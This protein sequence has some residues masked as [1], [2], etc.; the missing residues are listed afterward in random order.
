MALAQFP[1]HRL[2]SAL[3]RYP[4]RHRPSDR[5][6]RNRKSAPPRPLPR[7]G[8]S[9][10]RTRPPSIAQ[11][12]PQTRMADD[13]PQALP[14]GARPRSRPRS[15]S[16]QPSRAHR[17]SRSAPHEPAGPAGSAPR[18]SHTAW[19]SLAPC[20]GLRR[21]TDIPS[22]ITSRIG[23]SPSANLKPTPMACGTT[24]SI[25]KED[26]RI[27]VIPVNRLQR[28][29][30]G[31]LGRIAQVEKRTGFLPQLPILRKIASG[32]THEPDRT[33]FRDPF[34]ENVE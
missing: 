23:P 8:R 24:R 3:P 15:Y 31:K 16:L 33:P 28:H 30:A 11:A 26:G 5:R 20:K 21:L 9:D 12:D 10:N 2:D 7:S 4:R 6:P 32:L 1:D 34:V 13:A 29:F 27:E 18:V 14:S 22:A 17:R 19:T 25:G